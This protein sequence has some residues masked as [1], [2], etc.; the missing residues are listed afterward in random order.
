MDNSKVSDLQR[1]LETTVRGDVLFDEMS[2]LLFSTDASLY[3][4]QP[5]G[6]VLPRNRTDIIQTVRLAAQYGVPVLPRGGGTSLAGQTVTSGLVIDCSKYMNQVLEINEKERWA[7]VQPGIILDNLNDSL[8]RFDLFFAPDVATSNRANVGGMIGNNSSGVRSIRYGKTVD[9]VL[10]LSVVLSSGIELELEDLDGPG[11]RQH[12]SLDNEEG[13]L[14]RTVSEIIQNNTDEIQQRFPKVMR[15]VSGYNLDEF[16]D[17][18]HFNLS[19]LLVGSEGT[20]GVVTEAKLNLERIPPFK[21]LAVLHFD[22]LI[23]SIRSVGGILRYDP[24]A[25]EI[26]DRYGLDLAL[27]N[28]LVAGLCRQFIH[29][30][31]QAVLIVEFSGESQE[32]VHSSFRELLNDVELKKRCS[33]IYEA[34]ENEAQQRV[35]QVRK[36][37]LGVML[38]IKGDEKPLPF[39]EDSAIPVEHLGDYI[40][41]LLEICRQYDRR[42]AL[43]AHASVGVI[44]VRPILNLKRE[45][46]VEIMSSI[47]EKAFQLVRHYGGSW[48]GEHGDGLVRSYKIREFFGDQLCG[49]FKQVKEAFDPSGLMNPGKI[50]DPPPMTENL[51]I[52]PGYRTSFPK[53]YYRFEE[54][55]GMD[56]AIE[57]CTGVGQCRKTL[58]GVMCPSYVATLDEEDST[59]GRAN[60]LRSAIAGDLGAEGFTSPRLLEVLDL[61][62]ECKACK[63]ECPSNVDMAKL[64]AEFLAHYYEKHGVPFEKRLLGLT[65]RSAELSSRTPGLANWLCQNGLFRWLLEKTAGIDRRRR[66]PSFANQ[67]LAR[68]HRSR[69]KT[70]PEAQVQGR[71]ALFLDTF[72]NFY[73]PQ[74]GIAAVRL[75][76]ALGYQVTLA[77]AGCCGRPLI[78]AGLLKEAKQNGDKVVARLEEFVRDQTPI[79]LLEPSC[80]STLKDDYPDLVENREGSRALAGCVFALEEFLNR[81]DVAPRLEEALVAGPQEVLF[82]GH[83]QQRALIGI[84]DTLA[85]L[86]KLQG[87]KVNEVGAGCCG[88]AGSFGYEK[89]H[90][91]LSRKIGE[92]HL[93]S[94]VRESEP[95]TEVIASGFSCRCQISHFTDRK[96]LHPAEVLASSLSDSKA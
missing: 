91:E 40:S 42:M 30:T 43:Y 56:R 68:W 96:A 95:G 55:G 76:E 53:T 29:G 60:A 94:S 50:V 14:Y 86:Q 78:S 25:V 82:H 44:H 16:L 34:W 9:H 26:L 85:L 35:W 75:L 15:R 3:Q 47:S 33:H 27:E 73:E 66:L 10:A 93:L 77:D 2:R 63:S 49:A 58:A 88:M 37:A 12:C 8:Q 6:V 92:R 67:T 84:D 1:E 13:H 81:D 4:I 11:L 41:Q 24:S 48:S 17:Q 83:C 79:I 22:D 7:R 19:K 87:T 23:E 31:P 36:N 62:L 18:E 52:H 74:V 90:Y 69:A 45:E 51:R 72:V 38:G 57:L 39:I 32:Q 64:K 71:V 89:E 80:Y 28:P 5:L 65:R 70:Q 20:L 59:R 46:D 61:C 21:V 54:E